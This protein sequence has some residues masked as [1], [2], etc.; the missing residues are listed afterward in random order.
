M[1]SIRLVRTG[2]V[3]LGV[4]LVLGAV[5]CQP[6]PDQV[7]VARVNGKPIFLKEVTSTQQFKSAVDNAVLQRLL[8]EAA[9]KENIVITDEEINNWIKDYREKNNNYTDDLEWK[10]FIYL[11]L[12]LSSEE[13]LRKLV[14]LQLIQEKL[15]EKLVDLSEERLKKEWEEKQAFYKT[16]YAQLNGLSVE[17]KQ[18]LTYEDVKD[19]IKDSIKNQESQQKLAEYMR[20]LQE[21]A[22]IEYTYIPPEVKL[23]REQLEK[24]IEQKEKEQL[25]AIKQAREEVAGQQD[26][27]VAE[28][29]SSQSEEES[30]T[31]EEEGAS[32]GEQEAKG[33]EGQD[34]GS[35][36]D[37]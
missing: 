27:I 3:V 9:A 26:D 22:E 8:E 14:R 30:P 20:K 31:E 18:K 12:Q 11:R 29:P 19:F 35:E 5:S 23:K 13:E 2:A 1:V 21:G 16:L 37:G 36:Q 32:G 6:S 4:A 25:E 34:A 24:E 17:E 33:E 10:K 7:E 15:A 28:E